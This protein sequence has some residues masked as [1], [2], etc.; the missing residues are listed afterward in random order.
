MSKAFGSIDSHLNTVFLLLA[1]SL[2]LASC[3]KDLDMTVLNKTLFE[4]VAFGAIAVEDAWEV[5]V[6]QDSLKRGVKIEYSAFLEEYLKVKQEGNEL[7]IGFT[8]RLNIPSATV[9][10][11]MVYVPT[12][13]SITLTEAAQLTLEGKFF[14]EQFHVTVDQASVI[15]GGTFI[16]QDAEIVLDNASTWVDLAAEVERCQVTT[17]NTSV[18]K[19]RILASGSL[20]LHLDNASRMTLYGDS[21]P[22]ASASLTS[23]SVLNML[24]VEVED[25]EIQLNKASEASVNVSGKLHGTLNEASVLYYQ[26]HPDL[27]LD[28]DLTSSYRPL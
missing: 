22:Q 3:N 12:L 25:L 24:S 19:G 4:D 28:C 2:T 16:G 7:T 27:D 18:F 15:R 10:R 21:A 26:G 6:I 14:A 8:N 9:F 13:Q 1:L 20:N 23:A 11:A 5:T 17:Q